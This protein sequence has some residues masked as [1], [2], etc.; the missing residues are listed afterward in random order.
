MTTRA[1]LHSIRQFTREKVFQEVCR[2]WLQEEAATGNWGWSPGVLST[3]WPVQAPDGDDLPIVALDESQR[4][5]L[6]ADTCWTRLPVGWSTVSEF[7]RR[8]RAL[9]E[10]WDGYQLDTVFFS[11]AGFAQSARILARDSQTR[12]I[13]LADIES[14]DSRTIPR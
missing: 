10:A 9:T 12:L 7:V 1:I 5:I 11:R 8:V 3:L 2:E 13:S 14:V 6:V 4:R